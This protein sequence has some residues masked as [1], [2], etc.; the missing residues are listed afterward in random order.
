MIWLNAAQLTP[1]PL[2]VSCSPLVVSCSLEPAL[3]TWETKL[4]IPANWIEE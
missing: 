3:R 4:L 1:Q 2:A